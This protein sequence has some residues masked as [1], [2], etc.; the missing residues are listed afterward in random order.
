MEETFNEEKDDLKKAHDQQ[1]EELNMKVESLNKSL[2]DAENFKVLY[3]T[4]K[5]QL[6]TMKVELANVSEK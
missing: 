4:S 1:L 6:Q 2:K 3:N 5:K